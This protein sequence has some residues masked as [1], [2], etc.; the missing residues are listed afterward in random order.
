[1]L[2]IVYEQS[3]WASRSADRITYDPLHPPV[4]QLPLDW[5]G[6]LDSD[7][8]LLNLPT[9]TTTLDVRSEEAQ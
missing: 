1:M 9:E 5:T 2:S 6:C 8:S 7:L 3:A 4:T